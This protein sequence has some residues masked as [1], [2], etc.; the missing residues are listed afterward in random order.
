[1]FSTLCMLKKIKNS[2]L[3]TVWVDTYFLYFAYMMY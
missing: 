2:I 3:F 1:M